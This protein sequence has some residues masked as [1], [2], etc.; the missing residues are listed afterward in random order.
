MTARLN[1]TVA[2]NIDSGAGNLP[3]P[4]TLA[5]RHVDAFRP[6]SGRSSPSQDVAV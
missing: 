5:H 6:P 2:V 1:F 3:P 4:G